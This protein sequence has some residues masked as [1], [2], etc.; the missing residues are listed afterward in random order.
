LAGLAQVEFKEDGGQWTQ[1][2]TETTQTTAYFRGEID[3]S[4]RFQVR[5]MDN[6]DNEGDWV[7]SEVV[8]IATVT[9]YYTFINTVAVEVTDRAATWAVS[10]SRWSMIRPLCWLLN[11][12]IAEIVVFWRCLGQVFWG[13]TTN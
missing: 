11:S 1:W 8:E 12:S 3:K 4:Y 10:R 7:E 5:A 13:T 2:L 9:K 6:V